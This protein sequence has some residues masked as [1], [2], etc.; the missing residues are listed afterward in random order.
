MLKDKKIA[1]DGDSI[2]EGRYKGQAANGGAYAKIIS[3]ITGCTYVNQA[4]GGGTLASQKSRPDTPWGG[5]YHSVVDNLENLPDDADLYCFDGGIND[6]WQNIELGDFDPE[7]YDSP[8]DTDTVCG[9]LEYVFRYAIEKFSDKPVCFVVV[10]KISEYDMATGKRTGNTFTKKNSANK[11]YTFSECRQKLIGIC[12]KYA[13]PYYDA[14][15]E[16]GLNAWNATV[17]NAY[18]TAGG[19][20]TA[21]Q[22]DGCHPN[23]AAYRRYYVPQLI[24]LFE[25]IMP[26]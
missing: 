8:L 1:Y 11:P 12:E 13:I 2:C 16:S 10:H 20:C 15:A 21:T 3:D 22:G 19:N 24:D 5:K 17:N 26:V 14:Y 25:R 23:E 7:D 18:L 4:V 9:A 6:Y